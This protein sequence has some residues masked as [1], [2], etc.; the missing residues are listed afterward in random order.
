MKFFLIR[1]FFSNFCTQKSLLCK[2]RIPQPLQPGMKQASFLRDYTIIKVYHGLSYNYLFPF[3]Y[4]YTTRQFT[5]NRTSGQIIKHFFGKI[6]LFSDR[7]HRIRIITGHH[8]PIVH[9]R[10]LLSDKNL[11]RVCQDLSKASDARVYQKYNLQTIRWPK[12]RFLL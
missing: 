11:S 1:K 2:F 6:R 4:I 7:H 10:T 9:H 3:M 5:R 8:I 12:L